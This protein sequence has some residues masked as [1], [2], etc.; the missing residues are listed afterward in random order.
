M[1]RLL[2]NYPEP[3]SDPESLGLPEVADD[4]HIAMEESR[5]ESP[6]E[7][8]GPDPAPLPGRAPMAIDRYGVT[9]EEGRLGESL[10]YKLAREEPVEEGGELASPSG[11]AQAALVD[12]LP[13]DNVDLGNDQVDRPP[14]EVGLA[15][16]PPL[17]ADDS[18]VSLYDRPDVT[19]GLIRPIGRLVEPD[20]GAHEDKIKEAV[21]WDAGPDGGGPTAEEMAIHETTQ[22]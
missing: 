14:Q 22:P 16:E 17:E 3:I 5:A 20:E 10:E 6:R 9:P 19:P 18:P 13:G 12:N 7:A 1:V 15:E 8:D 21:A 11:S 4:D 2:D